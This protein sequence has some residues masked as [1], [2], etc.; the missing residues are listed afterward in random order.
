MVAKLTLEQKIELLGGVDGMFTHA[1]PPSACRASRCPT[2]RWACAPGDRPR[3]MPAAWR[4]PPPGTGV[5]P[6]AG[7]GLGKDARARSV[8]FLL[9][10]GVNIARSPIAGR[11]FEYL[12]E[13]PFLNA[14]WWFRLS[15]ACSPRA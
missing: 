15:R 5:R 9:G 10:P 1:M 3:P 2:L 12:S 13:D 11:N 4:W 6:Q 14:A 7:R 8:N